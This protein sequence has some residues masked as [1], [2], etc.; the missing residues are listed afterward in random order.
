MLLSTSNLF[1]YTAVHGLVQELAAKGRPIFRSPSSRVA[2]AHNV[3]AFEGRTST[4]SLESL[5]QGQVIGA[6][7]VLVAVP[8]SFGFLVPRLGDDER[9]RVDV[10]VEGVLL[11]AA[12]GIEL[13]H[14]LQTFSLDSFVLII[15][16]SIVF[17]ARL[18]LHFDLVKRTRFLLQLNCLPPLPSFLVGGLFWPSERL[19][20]LRVCDAG[21][22]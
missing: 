11:L 21:F 7:S 5:S 9:V 4:Y 18:C 20:G 12:H 15:L 3:F 8:V 6:S 16:F 14:A 19:F 2:A 22:A 17:P 13:L 1:V 10:E